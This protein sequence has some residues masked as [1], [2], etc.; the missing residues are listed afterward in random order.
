[1]M[2]M[3]CRRREPDLLYAL[4][5]GRAATTFGYVGAADDAFADGDVGVLVATDDDAG[6]Q[7][8]EGERR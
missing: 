5:P 7:R 4:V 2:L 8:C 6:G 3:Q 1:M